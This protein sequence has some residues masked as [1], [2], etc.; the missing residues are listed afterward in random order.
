MQFLWPLYRVD[1][2]C[3]PG[4][5]CPETPPGDPPRGSP[6]FLAKSLANPDKIVKKN[7]KKNF[8]WKFCLDLPVILARISGD[9]PETPR[10]G[11]PG[12]LRTISAGTTLLVHTVQSWSTK[13]SKN[14]SFS[15]KIFFLYEGKNTLGLAQPSCA[16]HNRPTRKISLKIIHLFTFFVHEKGGTYYIRQM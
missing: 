13:S 16:F 4:R 12:G 1:Q 6:D 10:G 14:F 2:Q 8:F 7:A 3:C 11:S 9:P 5:N 15:L